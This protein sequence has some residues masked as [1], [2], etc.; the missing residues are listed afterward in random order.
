MAKGL[1]VLLI[2]IWLATSG[3]G[4]GALVADGPTAGHKVKT[5]VFSQTDLEEIWTTLSYSS[6]G[7]ISPPYRVQRAVQRS[8]SLVGTAMLKYVPARQ[9]ALDARLIADI[10]IMLENATR[11]QQNKPPIHAGW[12]S[13]TSM[14]GFTF[15]N[16][17][18][19][20]GG[21]QYWW[22]SHNRWPRW[23]NPVEK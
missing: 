7:P 9:Q 6:V 23:T 12:R 19:P 18:L 22:P 17:S 4:Y 8:D 20:S 1:A 2:A 16:A 15:V 21:R 11:A 3:C 5:M 14:P 10:G 13:I